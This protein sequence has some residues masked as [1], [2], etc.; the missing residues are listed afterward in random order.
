MREGGRAGGDLR[1]A[2]SAAAGRESQEKGGRGS[3]GALIQGHNAR[4]SG[5]RGGGA[6][7]FREARGLVLLSVQ[8]RRS[9]I[10]ARYGSLDGR[11]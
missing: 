4:G 1:R 10:V 6:H 8:W 3:H 7:A 5:E 9:T 11:D 2:T